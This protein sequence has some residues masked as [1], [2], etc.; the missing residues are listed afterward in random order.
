MEHPKLIKSLRWTDKMGVWTYFRPLSTIFP[1]PYLT[2]WQRKL[3]IIG[4]F[5]DTYLLD[6]YQDLLF[7]V[8]QESIILLL[9]IFYYNILFT[10][11]IFTR[12][13]FWREIH[14]LPEGGFGVRFVYGYNFKFLSFNI[15]ISVLVFEQFVETSVFVFFWTS[16]FVSNSIFGGPEVLM[17]I[18]LLWSSDWGYLTTPDFHEMVPD[19]SVGPNDEL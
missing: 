4:E 2:I 14:K 11:K 10:S 9:V 19:P 6:W 7:T 3:R 18:R 8:F 15:C 16:V 1:C 12:L 5:N 17:F 13:Y